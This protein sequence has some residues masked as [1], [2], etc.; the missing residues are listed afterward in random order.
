[1][2]QC[3]VNDGSGGGGGDGSSCSVSF[4][5]YFIVINFNP[6]KKLI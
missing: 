4:S 2:S 3:V 6:C 1:M 5:K